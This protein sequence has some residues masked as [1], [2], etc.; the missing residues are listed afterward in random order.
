ML[1]PSDASRKGSSKTTIEIW[2]CLI[3]F[4]RWLIV[5]ALSMPLQFQ[6]SKGPHTIEFYL[7]L[8]SRSPLLLVT[9]LSG[10]RC[11]FDLLFL[12]GVQFGASP[13]P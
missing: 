11:G 13:F 10:I 5:L 12:T 3:I 6:T 1:F 4:L 8:A 7:R 2:C 9:M